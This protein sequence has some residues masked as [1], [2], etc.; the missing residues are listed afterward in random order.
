MVPRGS[1]VR[2]PAA[3]PVVAVEA[4][5]QVLAALGDRRKPRV[6]V[7]RLGAVELVVPF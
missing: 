2:P 4:W 1:A 7:R 6:A 3:V 5:G